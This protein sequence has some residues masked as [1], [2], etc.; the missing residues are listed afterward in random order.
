M[1]RESWAEGRHDER[2]AGT[3][4]TRTIQA[5]KEAGSLISLR[6]L[7]ACCC[8]RKRVNVMFFEL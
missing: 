5:E 6:V 8:G 4:K 7:Q 1:S 3:K 2:D